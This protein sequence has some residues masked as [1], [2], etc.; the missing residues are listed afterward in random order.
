VKADF[1]RTGTGD[2]GDDQQQV[3]AADYDPNVDRQQEEARRV[4]AA[5]KRDAAMD[6]HKECDGEHCVDEFADQKLEG[7]AAAAEDEIED[8]FAINPV[9]KKK[10]VKKGAKP[11]RRST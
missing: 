10:K 6:V 4:R 2:D 8:M 3:S 11:V 9:H 7:E 5:K 1:G